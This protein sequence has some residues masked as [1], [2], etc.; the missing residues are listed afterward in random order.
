MSYISSLSFLDKV[1]LSDGTLSF[2]KDLKVGDKVLSIRVTQEGIK[3][4]SDIFT[5]IINNHRVVYQYEFCEATIYSLERQAFSKLTFVNK[6]K[7]QKN[8]YVAI[9][10]NNL[11]LDEHELKYNQL[12]QD[13][14][15]NNSFFTI[16]NIEELYYKDKQA[17][18]LRSNI[19]NPEVFTLKKNI[20][21]SFTETRINSVL[22][23]H[24][25]ENSCSLVINGGHFYFTKNFILLSDGIG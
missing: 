7:I 15:N 2:V 11:G 14:K 17:Y 16:A 19:K 13:N 12:T 1:Y 4:V 21:N 23:S 18:S 8:Q 25:T 22:D 5:K 20:D 9:K 24:G 3:D 6:K 10:L